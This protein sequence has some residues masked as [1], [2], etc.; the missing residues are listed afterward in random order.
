MKKRLKK[1]WA[2]LNN[3]SVILG[4][5]LLS[6]IANGVLAYLSYRLWYEKRGA[7]LNNRLFEDYA[8]FYRSKFDQHWKELNKHKGDIVFIG[9]SNTEMMP[10]HDFVQFWG[11][12]E[13]ITVAN[14]GISGNTTPQ[15]L[16]RFKTDVIDLDPE[17]VV[18][19]GGV[20]DFDYHDLSVEQ[21]IGNLDQMI[22][23][24]QENNIKTIVCTILPFFKI[25]RRPYFDR[26]IK[27][28]AWIRAQKDVV[29][30]DYFAAFADRQGYLKGKTRYSIDGTHPTLEG[31]NLIAKIL[32][33]AFEK[34]DQ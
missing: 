17:I 3:K 28:N 29:V 19:F 6:L 24:A 21:T 7:E 16:E 11:F 25:E 15:M 13:G 22:K 1:Q 30:A 10:I 34:L 9:D 2:K 32:K 8:Y 5:L 33:E 23:M 27:L 26:L 12:K 14:K 4:L 18:I 31:Y 20:C